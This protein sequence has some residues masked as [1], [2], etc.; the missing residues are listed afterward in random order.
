[1]DNPYAANAN[2]V[3]PAVEG[4]LAVLRACQKH[5][6]ERCVITSSIFACAEGYAHGERPDPVSESDWSLPKGMQDKKL[7][8]AL[9][10]YESEKAAW[11]FQRELPEA[12]RF[13]IVTILPGYIMGPAMVGRGFNSGEIV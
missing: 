6:I 4:T 8:Y 9:S 1:M 11:D 2:L 7:D 12:E 3:K 5:G 10:K 13:E